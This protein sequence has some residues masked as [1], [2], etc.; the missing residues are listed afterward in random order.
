MPNSVDKQRTSMQANLRDRS[1]ISDSELT[2]YCK[3]PRQKPNFAKGG[4][5]RLVQATPPSYNVYCICVFTDSG[6][7]FSDNRPAVAKSL[8]HTTFTPFCVSSSEAIAEC[9]CTIAYTYL[10]RATITDYRRY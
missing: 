2:S 5:T 4:L 1:I 10:T 9:G 3:G 7:T 6:G 8:T